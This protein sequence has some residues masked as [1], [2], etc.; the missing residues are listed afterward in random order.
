[1]KPSFYVISSRSA[2]CGQKRLI[3]SIAFFT[4]VFTVLWIIRLEPLAPKVCNCGGSPR[5]RIPLANKNTKSWCSLKASARGP[6]QNV[7]SYSLFTAVF[8]FHF[9]QE[10]KKDLYKNNLHCNVVAMR[11]LYPGWTMRIYTDYEP[12]ELCDFSCQNDV[13]VCDVR[14]LSHFG[15]FPNQPLLHFESKPMRIF[16]V[17]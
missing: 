9:F 11:K 6:G 14:Q 1:M 2:F 12:Q 7:I 8:K 16:P 13:D 3:L 4:L 5:N 15:L 10:A 17:Q